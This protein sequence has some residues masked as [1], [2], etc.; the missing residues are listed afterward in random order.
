ML[1]DF[2]S[3][4][5]HFGTLWIKGLIRFRFFGF[6]LLLLHCVK[7]PIYYIQYAILVH[8]LVHFRLYTAHCSERSFI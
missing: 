1:P 6:N 7:Y 4:I 3:V 2:Q 5:G 8:L